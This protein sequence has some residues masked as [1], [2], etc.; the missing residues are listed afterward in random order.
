MSDRIFSV[1]LL[2]ICGLIGYQMWNLAVPFAYEP[3]GPK[4]F[5]ILLA[6]LMGLCCGALLVSPDRDIH[7]P[8][9]P[10]LSRGTLLV[11][12]LIAY[13]TLFESLGFPLATAGMVVLVSRLFAGRWIPA[14]VAGLSIGLLGYLLFDRLLQVSLPLGRIWGQ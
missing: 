7:W 9:P 12:V 3:V 11:A 14:L 5:P 1:I 8:A 4:A 10:V 2:G 6:V 13:A